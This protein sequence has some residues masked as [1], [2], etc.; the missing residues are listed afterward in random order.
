MKRMRPTKGKGERFLDCDYYDDCLSRAALENWPSLNCEN[1]DLFKTLFH[2]G[3]SN[4]SEEGKESKN[5]RMCKECG[6]R[7]TIQP[8]SPYCASCLALKGKE[9]RARKK[10]ASHGAL[11]PEKEKQGV[12]AALKSEKGPT[13]TIQEEEII[14]SGANMEIVLS[15]DKYGHLLKEIERLAEEEVRP[16]ELQ[17]IYMLKRYLSNGETVKST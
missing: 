2:R 5:P 8:T 7:P 14:D 16:V 6:I 12:Q 3:K 1:C 11:K 4:L 10:E 9:A 15:F 17:V 13:R